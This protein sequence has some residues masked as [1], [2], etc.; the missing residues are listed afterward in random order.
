MPASHRFDLKTRAN[1]KRGIQTVYVLVLVSSYI[2]IS[3][4]YKPFT[5]TICYW[6]LCILSHP[7]RSLL[8]IRNL[9]SSS[10]DSRLFYISFCLWVW[11]GYDR[12]PRLRIRLYARKYLSITYSYHSFTSWENVTQI[13]RYSITGDEFLRRDDAWNLFV[14]DDHINQ[15]SFSVCIVGLERCAWKF[16]L[17]VESCEKYEKIKSCECRSW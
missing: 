10:I 6:F 13:T 15:A 17:S 12:L 3:S 5:Q 11:C 7:R 9:R 8:S 4:C 16:V 1:V 2:N 14:C